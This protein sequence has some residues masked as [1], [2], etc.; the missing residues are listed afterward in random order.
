M[1]SASAPD[2]IRSESCQGTG[3]KFAAVQH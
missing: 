1:I 3:G 2:C